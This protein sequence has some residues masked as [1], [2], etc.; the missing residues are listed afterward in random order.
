M[1]GACGAHFTPAGLARDFAIDAGGGRRVIDLCAGIGGLGFW[2]D[3]DGR[4]GELVCV[5]VNPA[6]VEVGRKI[7]PPSRTRRS[8]AARRASPARARATPARASN[9][10]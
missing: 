5:E 9:T 6:Y 3:L 1:N 10:T 8:A 4:A 7:L 2:L